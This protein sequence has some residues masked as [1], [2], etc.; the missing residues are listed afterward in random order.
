MSISRRTMLSGLAAA[1]T[2]AG[3]APA[4]APAAAAGAGRRR[5]A[6][7][8]V[9]V[10]WD[11]FDPAY[12][13]RV[14]TPNLDRLAA[15]GVLTVAEATYH[16]VSNPC[17]AS[18][19]TG[20]YPE[21]HGNVAYVFDAASGRAQGQSRFLAAET[22][23]ESLAAE[24][25]TVASVQWYMI[26][27]H[28][29]RYGD[30]EHLYVQPGGGFAQRVDVAIDILH[31]RPV[32]SGGQ[33][34]TVPRI[35]DLL[36]VYSSDLDGLG[37]NE[38]PDSPNLGP[39][40]A[41]HDHQLGRLIQATQDAGIFQDTAFLLTSDHGMTGW[42]RTLLPQ[43]VEAVQALGHSVE[44]VPSGSAPAAGT[45]VV[46]VPNAVRLGDFTLRGT[47]AEPA[48]RRRIRS[49]L[50]GLP[51][52]SRVLD[53]PALRALHASD[54][55]GDLVAEARPPYGFALDPP[56]GQWRGAH[57][58][59]GE[60]KVPL[61]LSGAGIRPGARPRGARLIDVAPTVAALLGTRPP[62]Q[63]QGRDLTAR[64]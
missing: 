58:S 21:V 64:P 1:G 63:A 43:V 57:G 25:R 3:T 13:G 40:L 47:A 52:I 23:A 2:L 38:G 19:S 20:A 54:K 51:E 60:I 18:M 28:G 55:L 6:R 61:L 11:G 33:P 30:P 37:H 59:L 4:A 45:E 34:V 14:P 39:L 42:N 50:R 32:D 49:A 56:A 53:E 44:V 7:H 27:D 46:I 26:Q 5:R 29:V 10:D 12:L 22:I 9:L 36:A 8:V 48:A 16:T 17:R 62:A 31:L 24:G 35:P 15:R 41:E